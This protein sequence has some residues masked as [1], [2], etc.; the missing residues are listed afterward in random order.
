[1][2][3]DTRRRK[4]KLEVIQQSQGAKPWASKEEKGEKHNRTPK[5]VGTIAV[6]SAIGLKVE[7]QTRGWIDSLLRKLLNP[8]SLY[9]SWETLSPSLMK[10]REY[11]FSGKGRTAGSVVGRTQGP[12]ERTN[13]TRPGYTLKIEIPTLLPLLTSPNTGSPAGTPQAGEQ[14]ILFW[15][16]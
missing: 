10:S 2:I 3:L 13:H 5:S 1:M 15:R 4:N 12:G 9:L 11:L 8:R 7:P 16:I 6:C 14:K